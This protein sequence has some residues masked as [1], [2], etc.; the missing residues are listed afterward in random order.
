MSVTHSKYI[1]STEFALFS[2]VC[3]CFVVTRQFSQNRN[4][5]FLYHL[6]IYILKYTTSCTR[7]FGI[8]G[9]FRVCVCGFFSHCLRVYWKINALILLI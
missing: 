2:Q 3:V 6:S 5:C 8:W 7:E 1:E 4:K 9:G